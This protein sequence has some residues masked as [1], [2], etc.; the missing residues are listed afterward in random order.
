MAASDG[1][2][3][4]SLW[5][6]LQISDQL[7]PTGAYAFSHALETYVELGLVHDRESCQQLLVNVCYHS[8]GPCDMVFCVQAFQVA[9]T[10][11]LTALVQLDRLLQAYKVPEELRAE[12]QH[13][14]QAFLRASLALHPSALVGQFVQDVQHGTAPGNHAVAFGVVAQGLGLSE[15]SAVQGYLYTVTA[16]WVAAALRLVP[17]G[18]TDGQRL[19]H[20]LAPTLLDVWQ[21]YRDLRPEEAWSCVPGLDIRSMQHQ[22]LYSRLF[23]S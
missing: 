13:T 3:G 6:L 17:L 10:H 11:N 7:F 15:D 19:L 4:S 16:G 23:R 2:S 8:L 5:S 12:S 1:L 21:Q 20:D 18:Q 22:R 9:A 14:G